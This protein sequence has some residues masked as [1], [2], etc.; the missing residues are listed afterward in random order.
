MLFL[1]NILCAHV[2]VLIMGAGLL[3]CAHGFAQFGNMGGH[4][5]P[6]TSG[7]VDEKDTLK[8]FHQ[9]MALQATSEQAV[10]FQ[11]AVKSAE[12]AN[13]E[14]EELR[15]DL[16]KRGDAAAVS[17]G[18]TALR[19]AIEK[20]RLE[21]RKFLDGLSPAQK[22]RFRDVTTRLLKADADLG[23]LEK[24]LDASVVNANPANARPVDEQLG[25]AL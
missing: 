10:E 1:R 23:E 13:Q 8:N 17:N 22:S 5:G 7:G 6:N 24:T 21:T 18:A 12:S 25:K 14:F 15:S 2:N 4:V 3:L 20:A 9:A 19:L 11:S 16:V